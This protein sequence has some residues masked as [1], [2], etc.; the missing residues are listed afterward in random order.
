MVM[1][2]QNNQFVKILKKV[3]QK[4]DDYI[5]GFDGGNLYIQIFPQLNH[6]F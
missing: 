1:V 5:Y 3:K 4:M 2:N 6:R